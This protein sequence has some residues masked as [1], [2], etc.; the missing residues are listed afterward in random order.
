MIKGVIKIRELSGLPARFVWLGLLLV[1]PQLVLAQSA[2]SL[3]KE[4]CSTCHNLTGPAPDT[5][6][7]LWLRKGPDLFYA[8][9][10]YKQDWMVEWLQ[11]PQ[12]IRPAGMFYVDH[13]KVSPDGDVVD[14]G[15]LKDH[16]KLDSDQA[17]LVATYLMTL[18]ARSEMITAGDYKPGNISPSM[19]E[20]MFDKFRGCMACHEI[21]PGY[22]GASGPEVYTVAKRL[23]ED[24]MISFLRNPPAWDPQT[25]M[26]NKHLKE[27]DLQKFVHYFKVLSEMKF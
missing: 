22:G 12:R 14:K 8:G 18:K 26:P 9:N 6:A 10:K 13:I 27:K 11:S 16:V 21:E 4:Q 3:L 5:V 2:E 17:R 24:Y 15:S 7:A 19:G 23:Q 25:F 20:M 1:L